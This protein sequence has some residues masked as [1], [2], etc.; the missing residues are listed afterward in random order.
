MKT[1]LN[2]VRTFVLV[3]QT[4]SVSRAAGLLSVTPGAVSQ[5]IG[6]LEE[7]L[8]VQLFDRRPKGLEL[9]E[10]GRRLYRGVSAPMN[11][12]EAE[13]QAARVG[14]FTEVLGVTCNASF[15]GQC[16]AP[17]LADFEERYPNISLRMETTTRVLDFEAGVVDIAVRQGSGG[18][19]DVSF[20][21]LSYD[22]QI[23]VATPEFAEA[24]GLLD[25]PAALSG[26]SLLYDL[27]NPTE[28]QLWFE[29]AGLGDAE[30]EL[31]KGFNDTLVMLG[32]LKAGAGG[33]GLAGRMLVAHELAS[34]E[35]V[36]IGDV[37]VTPEY[38]YYVVY[39]SEEKLSEAARNFRTWLTGWF[40]QVR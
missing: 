20:D 37:A 24:H 1:N 23:A 16:L 15:A 22:E 4:G 10:P 11:R 27:E 5:Q 17:R 25:D 29:A 12:I 40:G 21:L 14:P 9:T 7:Y 38:A 13:L 3:A 26:V 32:A 35:L 2:A 8:A 18:W 31:S 34:G 19:P 39:P 30:V 36:Q 33:V 6:K 28:W